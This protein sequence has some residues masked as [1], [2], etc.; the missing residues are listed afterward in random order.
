MRAN[1]G[2]CKRGATCRQFMQLMRPFNSWPM[3]I[4]K[5]LEKKEKK[6]SHLLNKKKEVHL[7]SERNEQR[8]E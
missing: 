6:I 7:A 1:K 2:K 5:K 8:R 3:K 4:R